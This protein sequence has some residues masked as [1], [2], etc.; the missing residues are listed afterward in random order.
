MTGSLQ[1]SVWKA[2]RHRDGHLK[3]WANHFVSRFLCC[4][5]TSTSLSFYKVGFWCFCFC[6]VFFL[7]ERQRQCKWK[8]GSERERESQV[9]SALS[10]QSLMWGSHSWIVR[11]WPEPKPRVRCLTDW[12]T[13]VPQV[14]QRCCKDYTRLYIWQYCI[15]FQT[16]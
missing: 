6:F 16:T 8:R 2:S 9:G 5:L 11:S 13:Q 4:Y 7:R 15:N 12:G 1:M 14:P 10:A 3:L